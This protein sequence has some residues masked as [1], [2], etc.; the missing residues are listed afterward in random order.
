MWTY[1]NAHGHTYAHANGHANANGHTDPHANGHTH[2]TPDAD[3]ASPRHT[4][5]A[6]H[7]VRHEG[8]APGH[9]IT[10]EIIA[11]TW[12]VACPPRSHL[13]IADQWPFLGMRSASTYSADSGV[14][15]PRHPRHLTLRHLNLKRT[16]F[17]NPGF[18]V[19][20][21]HAVAAGWQKRAKTSLSVGGKLGGD[22]ALVVSND[23]FGIGQRQRPR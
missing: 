23:P 11:N 12:R 3:A 14:A 10:D 16:V 4:A 9:R 20:K 19:L 22:N 21:R 8:R 1:T 18:P 5:T 6:A 13:C 17:A 15:L 7:T 2:A